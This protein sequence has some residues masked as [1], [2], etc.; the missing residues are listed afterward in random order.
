MAA[1]SYILNIAKPGTP[2]YIA[3]GC[4]HFLATNPARSRVTYPVH[5]R[6]LTWSLSRLDKLRPSSSQE[7]ARSA[8]ATTT[9][10]ECEVSFP[11]VLSS[12]SCILQCW[13]FVITSANL[14]VH[15]EPG[16]KIPRVYNH[17]LMAVLCGDVEVGKSFCGLVSMEAWFL[18]NS[19][20]AQENNATNLPSH[21]QRCSVLYCRCTA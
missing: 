18:G 14:V 5:N 15:K 6:L 17:A 7:S 21:W 1:G 9:G 20:L 11:D 16:S 2:H 12:H 8:P 19:V 3:N 13:R 10:V 4:S